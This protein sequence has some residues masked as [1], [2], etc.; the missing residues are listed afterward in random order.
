MLYVLLPLIFAIS[1]FFA[2]IGQGGGT[3]YVP[4]LIF[5]GLTMK[6][7]PS[8]SLILILATSSAALITYWRNNQVDW[9]LALVI[10]PPT[11]VMAFVGAYFSTLVA[12]VYLRS[13]L[14]GVLILGGFLMLR[15]PNLSDVKPADHTG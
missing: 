4:L 11:D 5:A 13:L 3:F 10:D 2:M 12:P 6:S 1:T 8:L 9:K 15:P 14:A 7:A